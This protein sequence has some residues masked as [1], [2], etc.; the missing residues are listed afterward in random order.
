MG[1]PSLRS[2]SSRSRAARA[3]SRPSGRTRLARRPKY[4]HAGT[5]P[6]WSHPLT[7]GEISR[8]ASL[9]STR[10][11]TV[12]AHLVRFA[13]LSA[14]DPTGVRQTHTTLHIY[15]LYVQLVKK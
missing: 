15:I 9:M 12:A 7:R 13:V 4:W 1:T 5:R 11:A 2:P 3:T 14:P 8:S 10:G 6:V